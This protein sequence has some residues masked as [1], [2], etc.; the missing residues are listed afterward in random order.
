MLGAAAF[1]TIVP[2][3]PGAVGEAEFDLAPALPWFPLIGAVVGA[4]GGALRFG[5][6]P[7][8]GRGPG[9]VVAMAGMILLT[10]GLH[11]DAL[12][13]T[14]DGLGVRGDRL[15]RLAVMRDSTLG[16]FGVLAL[17]VWALLLLTSLDQLSASHALVVL[18]AAETLARLAAILHGWGAAPARP[19]GLG[20]ALR[21]RR[22]AV[23]AAGLIAVAVAVAA[24]GPA[25]AGLGLAVCG[26]VAGSSVILAR[27]AIGGST[28]DTLG[29]TV[30]ATEA[31]VCVALAATWR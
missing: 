8:L 18:I 30:A 13:D 27:R 5:L 16:A 17:I 22:P 6:D 14:F 15:R 11:Q 9:T 4:L 21:V 20:A 31:L 23:L 26:A 24:A 7:L 12:A 19:E 25:R 29:A 10:G 1:L 3:P 2:V 28:G